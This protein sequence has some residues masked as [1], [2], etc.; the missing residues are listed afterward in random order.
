MKCVIQVEE[1]LKNRELNTMDNILDAFYE[2]EPLDNDSFLKLKETLTRIG[3]RS[4]GVDGAPIL[5]QTAHVLHK[6]GRYFIVHFKQMFL[7]DGRTDKT[8]YTIQDKVRMD[9]ILDMLYRWNFV[10]IK[11]YPINQPIEYDEEKQGK[12]PVIAIKYKDI[13]EQNWILRSKYCI[14]TEKIRD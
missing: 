7:L 4:R 9:K 2:I 5:N 1:L 3:I 6:R 11:E 14:G 12:V 10:K 8:N 13:E